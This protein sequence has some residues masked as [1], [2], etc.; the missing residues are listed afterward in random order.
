MQG[1]MQ[2]V[3]LSAMSGALIGSAVTAG[4]FLLA[5]SRFLRS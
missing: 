4:L 2:V 3:F 1:I 5:L